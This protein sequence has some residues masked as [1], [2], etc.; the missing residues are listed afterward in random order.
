MTIFAFFVTLILL[1]YKKI[2]VQQ[3]SQLEGLFDHQ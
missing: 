1:N 2:K 3:C